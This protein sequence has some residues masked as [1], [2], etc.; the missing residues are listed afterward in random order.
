MLVS[1]A[2][3]LALTMSGSPQ[4]AEQIPSTLP[5]IA[6]QDAVLDDIVVRA[7]RLRETAADYVEEIGEPP[8]G[9]R[10]ARWN[11]DICISVTGMRRETAQYMIDR[12]AVRALEA[13]A[14]I[15]GPDCKPNVIILATDDGSRLAS[16]LVHR[17]GLAFRPSLSGTN[18]SRQALRRYQ[19]SQ[20]AVRWW[21]V[22]MPIE[23]DSGT[24]AAR[25]QGQDVGVITVRDVSRMRS[26]VRYDMAWAIIILDLSKTNGV[27]LSTLADHVAFVSLAQ[28]DPE[29]NTTDHQTILNA[30]DEPDRRTTAMTAW[31]TDYLKAL[32]SSSDN[33]ATERAQELGLIETLV[34]ARR[35]SRQ[36]ED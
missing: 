13:G 5:P 23:P 12:V 27:S 14:E 19:S 17:V 28:V 35:E 36:A 6:G 2:T 20:E 34:D 21:H 26:Q 18:L 24:V 31:D 33:R 29:A 8:R 22:A 10:I 25:L 30:F 3:A 15:A 9:A 7:R 32:Y 11:T 1:L 16:N 4:Q